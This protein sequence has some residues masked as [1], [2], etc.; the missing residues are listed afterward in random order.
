[1]HGRSC[2]FEFQKFEGGGTDDTAKVTSALKAFLCTFCEERIR[3]LLRK[4]RVKPSKFAKNIAFNFEIK[5]R[6]YAIRA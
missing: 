3:K 5:L 4:L 2:H 1:M 6:L